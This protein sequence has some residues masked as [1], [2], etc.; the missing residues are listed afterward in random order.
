MKLRHFL[1]FMFILKMKTCSFTTKGKCDIWFNP[2]C[3]MRV[4][5]QVFGWFTL[6]VLLFGNSGILSVHSDLNYKALRIIINCIFINY[7]L[8][9]LIKTMKCLLFWFYS[10]RW[11]NFLGPTVQMA[12]ITE[13][14]DWEF[15]YE[16]NFGNCVTTETRLFFS[17]WVRA[18]IQIF[19]LT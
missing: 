16:Q 12:T 11:P 8:P 4:T 3:L 6:S 10:R 2:M 1:P 15:F 17:A 7:S 9:L 14:V 19:L 18:R 13:A 5:Q